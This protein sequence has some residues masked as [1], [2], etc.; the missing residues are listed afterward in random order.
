M[1]HYGNHVHGIEPVWLGLEVF[2]YGRNSRKSII[3]VLRALKL[4][5][6]QPYYSMGGFV[7]SGILQRVFLKLIGVNTIIIFVILLLASS[8]TKCRSCSRTT[9][10]WQAAAPSSSRSSGPRPESARLTRRR[11][12]TI[13]CTVSLRFRRHAVQISI[14]FSPAKTPLALLS[15]IDCFRYMPGVHVDRAGRVECPGRPWVA[16]LAM[17][18]DTPLVFT[19]RRA[20]R[21]APAVHK[22]QIIRAIRFVCLFV[23]LQLATRNAAGDDHVLQDLLGIVRLQRH[24]LQLRIQHWVVCN[25]EHG[26]MGCTQSFLKVLARE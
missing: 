25:R 9:T 5:Y 23:E 18:H 6:F 21:M 17:R 12:S 11:S 26:Q 4:N 14:E 20:P 24:L 3:E 8:G 2:D 15:E 19:A 22:R 7:Q 16:I 1:D 10:S 13:R